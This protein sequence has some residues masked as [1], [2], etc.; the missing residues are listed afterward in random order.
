M[1]KDMKHTVDWQWCDRSAVVATGW[2]HLGASSP[3]WSRLPSFSMTL[4]MSLGLPRPQNGSREG[5]KSP[6]CHPWFK[7]LCTW[8]PPTLFLLGPLESSYLKRGFSTPFPGTQLGSI[9]APSFFSADGCNLGTSYRT[10]GAFP[11]APIPCSSTAVFAFARPSWLALPAW[12]SGELPH[13]F[14]LHSL[15]P[16]LWFLWGV[17][18]DCG[19]LRRS[20]VLASSR[21]YF[22]RLYISGFN[23]NLL[24]CCKNLEKKYV[25]W[26]NR[27]KINT[28]ILWN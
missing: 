5:V 22:Q 28:C 16:S 9:V 20:R 4:L 3:C 21:Q 13:L 24:S 1:D 23:R 15:W 7:V 14:F 26:C 6:N 19:F 11:I 17:G 8:D 10:S 27:S 25:L 2:L 12:C 18:E